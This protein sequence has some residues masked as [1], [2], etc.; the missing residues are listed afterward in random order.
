MDPADPRY[1]AAVR[2]AYDADAPRRAAARAA[3]EAAR[4]ARTPAQRKADYIERQEDAALE[5]ADEGPTSY[6]ATYWQPSEYT[7]YG[8]WVVEDAAIEAEAA[9]DRAVALWNATPGGED[10]EARYEAMTAAFGDDDTLW[11]EMD[12]MFTEL[13]VV[14]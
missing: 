13:G 12:A 4:K 8:E 9:W 7:A 10:G 3:R 6:P 1:L 2:T 11:Q 5:E 14:G